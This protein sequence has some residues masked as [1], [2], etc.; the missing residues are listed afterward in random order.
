MKKL[1][2]YNILLLLC[3]AAVAMA[4]FDPASANQALWQAQDYYF[5]EGQEL[6]DDQEYCEMYDADELHVAQLIFSQGEETEDAI[7]YSQGKVQVPAGLTLTIQNGEGFFIRMIELL[8]GEDV[9]CAWDENDIQ[10]AYADDWESMSDGEFILLEALT[11][12]AFTAIRIFALPGLS[13]M[14]I[15]PQVPD[16]PDAVEVYC[17]AWSG[18]GD[19]RIGNDDED[20]LGEPLFSEIN[21][22]D[23]L[24]AYTYSNEPGLWDSVQFTVMVDGSVVET[25]PALAFGV[26]YTYWSGL[27]EPISF[28]NRSFLIGDLMPQTDGSWR[29]CVLT[30]MASEAFRPRMELLFEEDEEDPEESEE[31]AAESGAE[32]LTLHLTAGTYHLRTILGLYNYGF[33]ADAAISRTQNESQRMLQDATAALTLTADVEGDYMFSWTLEFDETLT[34]EDEGYSYALLMVEFPSESALIGDVN[35]DGRVDVSDISTVAEYLF[36]G[37]PDPF[38][39]TAADANNDG[40]IDVSDISTIA[41]IIFNN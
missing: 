35:M 36:G 11:D 8:D 18:I 24:P 15:Y 41:E 31:A 17:L 5:A 19:D 22:A 29:P 4:A 12:Q 34:E 9:V 21:Y 3:C 33:A 10:S 27:Y 2:L 39:A 38:N 1:K 28:D 16:D 32:H 13:A 25:T 14:Y 6:L 7:T 30:E 37:T 20:P 23:G 40:D 26:G